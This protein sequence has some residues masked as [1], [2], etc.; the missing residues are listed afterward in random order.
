MRGL[1]ESDAQHEN[2]SYEVADINK[3]SE[4][5]KILGVVKE[6]FGKLDALWQKN[7]SRK[8]FV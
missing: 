7:W 3:T 2:I 8:I 1:K 6:K 5:K 4:I